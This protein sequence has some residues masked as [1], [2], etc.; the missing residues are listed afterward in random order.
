M[1]TRLYLCLFT[2][3]K[4]DILITYYMTYNQKYSEK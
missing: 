2:E 1:K 3:N 4:V